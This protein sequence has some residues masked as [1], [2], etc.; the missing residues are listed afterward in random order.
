MTRRW[1][2]NMARNI[3]R[4]MFDEDE[5]ERFEGHFDSKI[6]SAPHFVNSI[7]FLMFRTYFFRLKFARTMQWP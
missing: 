4:E 7:F 3:E 6:F 2:R 5:N 1:A